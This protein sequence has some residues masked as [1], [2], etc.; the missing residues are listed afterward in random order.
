M[1]KYG[2][3][4]RLL[5]VRMQ[6]IHELLYSGPHGAELSAIRYLLITG[7]ATFLVARMQ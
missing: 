2:K 4:F 5:A 3:H 7:S 6:K 1:G